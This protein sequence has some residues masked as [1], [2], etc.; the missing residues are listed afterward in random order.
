M[1]KYD[2]TIKQGVKFT[3]SVYWKDSTNNPYDLTGYSARMMLRKNYDSDVI[4]E[5]S[6]V[7]GRIVLD[8]LVGKVELELSDIETAGLSH[9]DFPCVYD[10]EVIDSGDV[11][12]KR[13]IEGRIKLAREATK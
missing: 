1:T 13:L 9:E 11:V 5:L 6:T 8:P 10:L 3:K 4:I 2:F 7:N 12:I